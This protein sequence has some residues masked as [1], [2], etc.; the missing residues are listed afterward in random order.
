MTRLRRMASASP[1]M[2]VLTRHDPLRHL[3]SKRSEVM[4]R[5]RVIA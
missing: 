5:R 1:S 2:T 3:S 4:R